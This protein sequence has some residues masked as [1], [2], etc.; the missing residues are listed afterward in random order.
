[1]RGAAADQLLCREFFSGVGN[2]SAALKEAGFGVPEPLEAY[3]EN[4]PY[5]PCHDLC[6]PEVIQ[7]VKKL[8]EKRV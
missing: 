3:P 5:N 7:R 4:Q 6:L 1:M 2:L 8:V